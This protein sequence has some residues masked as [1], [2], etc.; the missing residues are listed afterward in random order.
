MTALTRAV[1]QRRSGVY[2]AEPNREDLARL[3]A[4]ARKAGLSFHRVALAQPARKTE[5]L[6]TLARELRFPDWFGQ[7][8]DALQDALC[9]LSWLPRSR[10]IVLV[11]EEGAA[12]SARAGTLE[13]FVEVLR[14][15]A[16]YWEREAQTFLVVLPGSWDP[17]L[18]LLG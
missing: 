3:E 1:E 16:A 5:L 10:G 7:N 9:D 4:I 11:I 14:S 12:P 18:P 15:A 2:R 17:G 8:W 6:E 13:T